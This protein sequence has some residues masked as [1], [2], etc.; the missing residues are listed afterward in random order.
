MSELVRCKLRELIAR[1]GQPLCD[2]P[3]ELE[4]LL[5]AECPQFPRQIQILMRA[6]H[7]RI[8]AELLAAPEGGPWD[9]ASAP[10]EKR[11][12]AELRC[13]P[14]DV[15]WAVE[16]WAVALGRGPRQ[17]PPRVWLTPRGRSRD[18]TATLEARVEGAKVGALVGA[19]I[20]FILGIIVSV[21]EAIREQRRHPQ[22]APGLRYDELPR[23]DGLPAADEEE[24]LLSWAVFVFW[25]SGVAVP[26]ALLGL[27]I[28]PWFRENRFILTGG[29]VGTLLGALAGLYYSAVVA[30]TLIRPRPPT[31][32]AA[33]QAVIAT[34]VALLLGALTGVLGGAGM[35]F[36][37]DPSEDEDE[38]WSLRWG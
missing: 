36:I 28:G 7:C 35:Q 5:R 25:H 21:S 16:T 19:V 24:E 34:A 10:A 23:A 6:L 15:R 33:R 22:P 29:V 3:D 31:L 30:P 2:R 4:A 13:S 26:G 18:R 1:H 17:A 9:V 27:L 32:E 14:E 8:P 12:A 20:G 11:L 38:D 37:P